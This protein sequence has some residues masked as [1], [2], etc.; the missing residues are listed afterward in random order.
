MNREIKKSFKVEMYSNY[1][2]K[3]VIT[4]DYK[5][6][7]NKYLK[8]LDINTDNCTAF[9]VH[10]NKGTAWIFL[11]PKIS[12]G[13]AAHEAF[14]ATANIM[15]NIGCDLDYNSEEPYAYLLTFIVNKIDD[16]IEYWH[17]K[18]NIDPTEDKVEEI[19]EIIIENN[20]DIK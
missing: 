6:S 16:S 1:D 19:K 3:I 14:H 9:F 8:D 17:K 4:E 18:Y 15:R 10:D 5:E 2:L 11:S 13:I 20:L 7:V 12:F